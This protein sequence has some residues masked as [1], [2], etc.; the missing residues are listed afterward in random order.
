MS[1][2]EIGVII[3]FLL[4]GTG[5]STH[6]GGDPPPQQPAAQAPEVVV[7]T[8]IQ[9]TVP[10]YTEYVGQ[11]QSVDTVEIRSQ[12]TGFLKEFS[13]EEGSAVETGQLLFLIDPRPYEAA[14]AQKRASLNQ[15][16]A[17]LHK[18]DG[19][20]ERYRPL[21]DRHAVS[22]EQLDT[23]LA[24]QEE[25]RA[26]VEAARAEVSTAELNLGYTRISAP[27][28]GQIGQSQVKT[29]A[30]VQAGNTLLATIYSIGPIYVMFNISQNTY[31]Q[32]AHRFRQAPGDV[33]LRIMLA[34]NTPYSHTGKIDMVTPDVNT[35]TGTLGIR[36]VFPNPKALLKPGLF[37]RVRMVMAKARNALLVPKPAVQ[38]LQGT[39]SVDVVA[40]DNKVQFRS[41]TVEGPS[42]NFVIVSSGLKAGERVI[43]QGQQ[44]VRPGM[45]V[46]PAPFTSGSSSSSKS[47][48]PA[49]HR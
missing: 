38:E 42:G 11:A 7:A 43:V 13:F 39:Q 26:N 12:V 36:A 8:V 32:Y 2:R 15:N 3:L 10:I 23:A 48:S 19:D 27:I 16:L 25:A 46:K 1:P 49:S 20:V 24:V 30:L 14:L 45:V 18:A 29:G 31:L 41:V 40:P 33:P 22:K 9:K 34:E 21:Y 35:T 44:K 37:V 28:R 17:A 5:C 6:A 47:G 4:S